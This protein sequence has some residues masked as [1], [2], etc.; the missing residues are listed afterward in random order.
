MIWWALLVLVIGF[1]LIF[2]ELVIP[3]FGMIAVT[4]L[5][6]FT[7]AVI[8]AFLEST[9]A[10]FVFTAVVLVGVPLAIYAAVKIFRHSP[11]GKRMILTGPTTDLSGGA[12][13]AKAKENLP[14]KVGTAH[15]VLR[16]SGI[17][18]IDG[19]RVDVVTEGAVMVK[20]GV[21]VKVVEVEGNRVVVRPVE[22]K[23]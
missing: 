1:L 6:C 7:L 10:G 19:R 21:P 20:A 17:A 3:S 8:L 16:P 18:I 5:A 2:L 23:D 11:L 14:G 9:A 13:D 15:T 22:E 12:V 4:S